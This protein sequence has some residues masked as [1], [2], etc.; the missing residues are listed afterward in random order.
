MDSIKT[1]AWMN[2]ILLVFRQLKLYALYLVFKPFGAE[3]CWRI[4]AI[5]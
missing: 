4:H 1:T 3:M 5:V 2:N